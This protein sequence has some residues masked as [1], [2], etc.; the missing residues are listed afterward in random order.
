MRA[1]TIAKIRFKA[2][3]FMVAN[4]L[5]DGAMSLALHPD[6]CPAV[7]TYL[8]ELAGKYQIAGVA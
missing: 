7:H 1:Q 4:G 3:A 6:K 5:P 2:N 8:A